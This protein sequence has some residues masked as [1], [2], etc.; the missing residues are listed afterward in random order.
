MWQ[1]L[2]ERFQYVLPISILRK[3]LN[4]TKVKLLDCKD[5]QEYT[6]AYQETYNSFYSLITKDSEL[7]VKRALMLLQAA[8]F[9][10]VRPEYIGIKPIIE[11]K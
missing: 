11:L 10:N 6:N 1:I 8:L 2:Q 7:P 3:V 9:T 5:I 4:V